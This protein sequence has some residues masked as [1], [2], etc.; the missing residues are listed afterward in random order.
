MRTIEVALLGASGVLVAF[1]SPTARKAAARGVV[2]AGRAAGPV[3]ARAAGRAGQ[4]ASR[5]YSTVRATWADRRPARPIPCL[6]P[7]CDWT[8]ERPSSAQLLD[9]LRTAHRPA[10]DVAATTTGAGPGSAPAAPARTAAPV[11]NRPAERITEVAPG[12]R[13]GHQIEQLIDTIGLHMDQFRAVTR[14]LNTAGEEVKPATL[15]GL[16]EACTGML[17]S[18]AGLTS[19]ITDI[20]EHAD[21]EM[22]VDLRPV[23][24]LYEAAAGVMAESE[25]VRRAMSQISDL[26]AEV[27][28]VERKVAEGGVR[29]LNPRV[30]NPVAAS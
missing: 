15:L 6:D 12:V 26:Y 19:M 21:M 22:H 13:I 28:A 8:Q 5:R 4:S 24:K 10:G 29:P 20:A 17:T 11:D 9:H 16:L 18:I 27:I 14:T 25:T 23:G 30:V 3:A 1:Q 7:G 2:R